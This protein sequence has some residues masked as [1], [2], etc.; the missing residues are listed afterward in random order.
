M[1]LSDDELFD[2]DHSRMANWSG[3][4]AHDTLARLPDLYRNHLTIAKML[5]QW[6]E[7]ME[8]DF[9]R[10]GEYTDGCVQGYREVAAHLRQADL[11]PGAELYDEI[12]GSS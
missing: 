10:S 1:A 4:R 8:S 9:S 6:I 3:E 5:D 7:R 12:T 2:F 11:V